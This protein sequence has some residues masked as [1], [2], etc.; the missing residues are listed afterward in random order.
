MRLAQCSSLNA[1]P[2]FTATTKTVPTTARYKTGP[3]FTLNLRERDLKKLDY[4]H[5][6]PTHPIATEDQYANS[7]ISL[8]FSL[9]HDIRFGLWEI[10]I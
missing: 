1:T 6:L 2:I 3:G 10:F 7:L 8:R 9:P 5:S 4:L